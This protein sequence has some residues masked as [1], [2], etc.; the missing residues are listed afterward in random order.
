[1]FNTP[2]TVIVPVFNGLTSLNLLLESLQRHYPQP[3]NWLTFHFTD[4]AS[5]DP[6]V[7]RFYSQN[8]FFLRPDVRLIRHP[9]NLGYTR[10][11]NQAI[12][13]LVPESAVV[14]LNSDTIVGQNLFESLH[15][16]A[17]HNKY[18]GS[19][20][21]L[22]NS[23]T[24]CSLF[25]WPHGG[26]NPFPFSAEKI[27]QWVD[28]LK[29]CH[30]LIPTP[31]T[32]GFC[33]YIPASALKKVG[34]FNEKLFSRGYGEE[35]EWCLRSARLGLQ[36][37]IYTGAYVHHEGGQSFGK[38]KASLIK[39]GLDIINRLYPTYTEEVESFIRSDKFD[40][41]RLN[42]LCH[43]S[44]I[45]RRLEGKKLLIFLSHID[46]EDRMGGVQTHIRYLSQMV[47]DRAKLDAIQVFNVHGRWKIRYVHGDHPIWEVLLRSSAASLHQ[48][49][50]SL[51]PHSLAIHIHH[52]M[53]IPKNVLNAVLE[54]EGPKKI[55]SCHD[56]F[57]ACPSITLVG[58][59]KEFCG[60]P[61]NEQDCI[62]CLQKKY[63]ISDFSMAAYR[64]DSIGLLLKADH[65]VFPSATARDVLFQGLAT[66][67]TPE[68]EV[69]LQEVRKKA[70][71][72]EHALPVP[73]IKNK[74][75]KLRS[76][77]PKKVIFLGGLSEAKGLHLLQ[78]AIPLLQRHGFKTEVWGKLG[79][80]L[81]L[82]EKT[83]I[84]KYEGAE[85]L[86]SLAPEAHDAIVV[87]PSVWPE[88]FCYTAHEALL[89]LKTPLVSFALGHPEHVIKKWR[90]G[91]TAPKRTAEALVLAVLNAKKQ[92][93]SLLK[94]VSSFC[95]KFPF[96]AG[97]S[98]KKY[99]RLYRKTEPFPPLLAPSDLLE[100]LLS[101]GSPVLTET[102]SIAERFHSAKP[103]KYFVLDNF[104]QRACCDQM[105]AQF[106][107]FESGN[108]LNEAG[109]IGGKSTRA[110]VRKLGEAY[111]KFD[112]LMRS[113]QFLKSLGEMTGIPDLVYD[114]DYVGGGTHENRPGQ[115]LDFHIDF[116]HHPKT[117]L[118]R[119]L[120]LI[121][122]L[123]PEWKKEW[124][125]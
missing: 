70:L 24:I 123:N 23:A 76:R 61:K 101:E 14:L 28:E 17:L 48:A 39:K 12:R 84:I 81:N 97:L 89:F 113:P 63:Q 1:M 41:V 95:E 33:M 68:F 13:K 15:T 99:L 32:V 77:A 111:R 122:F 16:V 109:E 6:L 8:Q 114:P 31:T 116:N 55:V 58:P 53:H 112:D 35:N 52:T 18:L 102:M 22:S 91:T 2:L 50:I 64:Q 66:S 19:I 4:D 117:K 42:I 20:S 57:L 10:N 11:I 78:K 103:F 73:M 21:P 82:S 9:K 3:Q 125:G 105:L 119:R 83:K 27:S 115:D 104:L 92:Y 98:D 29:S 25:S 74:Q 56:Y 62:S 40:C 47:S 46:P 80:P 34:L 60:I 65:V 7:D 37:F 87:I 85:E 75:L 121:L 30:A 79:G 72:I 69:L 5:S 88:T 26:K 96:A 110:D 106:P 36:H 44:E 51:L 49:L 118:H 94:N 124:G 86:I 100:N 59:K 120:N 108:C 71:V 38:E 90:V 93:P 54:F 67:V 45:Q 43:L 107:A